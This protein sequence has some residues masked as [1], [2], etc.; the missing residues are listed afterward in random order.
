MTSSNRS[1][2]VMQGL[3]KEKFCTCYT[4]KPS[5][6]LTRDLFFFFSASTM[7]M[8]ATERQT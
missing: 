8:Q 3:F 6:N 5:L 7:K 2:L 1:R 4:S